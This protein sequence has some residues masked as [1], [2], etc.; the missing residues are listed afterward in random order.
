MPSV[1]QLSFEKRELTLSFER[2]R[3]T[4]RISIFHGTELHLAARVEISKSHE[5]PAAASAL[6]GLNLRAVP[7]VPARSTAIPSSP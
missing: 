3:I 1:N 6:A 7:P 2:I 4:E 5:L